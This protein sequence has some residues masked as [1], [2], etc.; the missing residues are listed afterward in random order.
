MY[1]NISTR[2]VEKN[3]AKLKEQ[4][5]PRRIGPA[6]GGFWVILKK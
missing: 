1:L 3:I 6:K 4:G 5:I 2:A